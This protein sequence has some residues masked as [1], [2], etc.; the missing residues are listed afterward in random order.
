MSPTVRLH[1]FTIGAC[2]SSCTKATT[3]RTVVFVAS[4]IHTSWFVV[5]VHLTVSLHHVHRCE[6]AGAD[7][8][9]VSPMALD[10]V[11]VHLLGDGCDPVGSDPISLL[12]Y[13]RGSLHCASDRTLFFAGDILPSMDPVSSISRRGNRSSRSLG[14]DADVVLGRSTMKRSHNHWCVETRSNPTRR[15]VPRVL[16]T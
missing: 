15:R 1:H 3:P 6:K 4:P 13:P 12:F 11:R 10:V 16:V 8:P 7:T 2:V 5:V 9:V 14:V